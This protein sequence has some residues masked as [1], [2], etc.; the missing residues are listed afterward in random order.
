[1][2]RANGF[3]SVGMDMQIMGCH[4]VR[5]VA[6]LGTEGKFEEAQE[7]AARFQRMLKDHR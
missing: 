4:F 2:F 3:F 5:K 1:M 7:N 6:E